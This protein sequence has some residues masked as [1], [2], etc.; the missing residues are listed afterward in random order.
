MSMTVN[1]LQLKII[2]C[3]NKIVNDEIKTNVDMRLER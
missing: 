2:E 3:Q 1:W